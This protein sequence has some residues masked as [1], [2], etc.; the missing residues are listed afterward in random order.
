MWRQISIGQYSAY[1]GYKHCVNLH[2]KCVITEQGAVLRR[3]V[4][5]RF[6]NLSDCCI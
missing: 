5:F 1:R 4:Y 2:Y 3:A 6:K